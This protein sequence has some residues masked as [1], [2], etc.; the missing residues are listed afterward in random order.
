MSSRPSGVW[1]ECGWI[2]TTVGLGVVSEMGGGLPQLTE[3]L[4]SYNSMVT[5]GY[6]PG[7]GLLG[8]FHF[9]SDCFDICE[10]CYNNL[11][12]L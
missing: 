4:F 3:R 12:Y 6:L 9:M 7:L 8:S 2:V 10:D 1:K 11:W 5:R